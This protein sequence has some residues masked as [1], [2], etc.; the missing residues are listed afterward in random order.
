[1]DTNRY[2]L[3]PQTSELLKAAGV[4]NLSKRYAHEEIVAALRTVLDDVRRTL[5]SGG[6][7]PDFH[8]PAF[9]ETIATVLE[10]QRRLNLRRVVN[11][12]GIIIHTNLG[13]APLAAVAIAAIEQ[14]SRGYV[15]I[16][17]N[18]ETGKRGSR[19]DHVRDLLVQLTGADDAV[20]VNNCAAA[21]TIALAAYAKNKEVIVSRGELIEIGGSFRIPDVITQ[22]GAKLREI[23]T[24]NKTHMADYENALTS[25]TAVVLKTHTSNYRVVGF[26]ATPTLKQLKSFTTAND[27]LLIED[28]GSGT[29]I[30]LS[31][32]GIPDEPTVRQSI[33]AGVDLV[34]F[35]G[36]KLLGGPQC[37]VIAGRADLIANIRKDPLLRA[38]RIDK[39]SLAALEAT[40]R[41]YLPPHD[42]TNEVP[43]LR[44]L[45]ATPESQAP[46]A[47]AL[48][49]QLNQISGVTAVAHSAKAE[50]GGGSLPAVELESRCV[51]VE[52]SGLGV[53][54]L[55][56]AMRQSEPAVIGRISRGKLVLDVRTLSD[57]DFDPIAL[58]VQAVIK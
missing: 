36:D 19:Y 10:I 28:L 14:A 9:G 3:I 48:A 24:T 12:T 37:G 42:P 6:N 51:S 53:Q 25:E 43:V 55:A 20:V 16:E 11:G 34:T 58:A 38:M 33:A 7:L 49:K 17:F 41:L 26:T 35:S 1:M 32:F 29:L 2:R 23:G 8:S 4:V 44:M 47:D 39:L 57:D 30:D 31:P 13:R 27:L 22:N 45:T 5:A 50:A 54:A 40:L 15:N 18:L 21:V 56:D 52:V 46:R